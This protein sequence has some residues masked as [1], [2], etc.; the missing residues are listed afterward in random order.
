MINGPCRLADIVRRN[1]PPSKT[2]FLATLTRTDWK[3]V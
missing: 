1:I 3:R 2:P